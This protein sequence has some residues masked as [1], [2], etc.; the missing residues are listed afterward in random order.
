MHANITEYK[1]IET[2]EFSSTVPPEIEDTILLSF[3]HSHLEFEATLYL[4]FLIITK[5]LDVTYREFQDHLMNM[6]DRGII[7]SAE[8]LG[9][10]CWTRSS[11]KNICDY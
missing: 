5:R 8:F 6:E 4:K 7:I 11:D 10:K 9:K 2:P 1:E 3:G